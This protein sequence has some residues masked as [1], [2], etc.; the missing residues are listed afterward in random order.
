MELAVQTR[1]IKGK[2]PSA[3]RKSGVIP[4]ELYGRGMANIHLSVPAKAFA[5][6][7]REAGE[8]TII[9]LTLE[10]EKYP[11]L[12]YDV[13][14]NPVSGEIAHIDFYRVRMDEKVTVHVPLEFTGEVPAEKE[15]GGIVNKSM[16]EIEIEALPMDVPH[17]IAVSLALLDELDKS[18]YVKDIHV[19]KGVEILVDPETVIA[20]VS[21]P[22][23]EEE[24]AAP[25]DV[26]E[27]KVE[28]D[29]KKEA[30]EK[31]AAT[32]EEK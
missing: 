23:V 30:R 19:P 14:H 25:V 32:E 20:T 13:A 27:V 12:I 29:E 1:E 11:T 31:E 8:S 5:K 3:L 4:A 24:I 21:V 2:K 10:Q 15:K 7:F 6:L 28:T 26:S 22:V 16:S 18:I 9:E 17:T